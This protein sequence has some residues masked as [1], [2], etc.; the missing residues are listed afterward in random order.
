MAKPLLWLATLAVAGLAF[1]P[2]YGAQF[3]RKRIAT[4]PIASATLQTAELKIAGMSCEVCAAT[5]QRKLLETPGVVKA[6]VRY[7]T[8]SATV[9]FD[10]SQIDTGM[11]IGIVDGSGYNASISETVQK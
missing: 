10:P 8:G 6:E 11:L 7:P 9:Q 2:S 4:A 3:V 1:F 5:I